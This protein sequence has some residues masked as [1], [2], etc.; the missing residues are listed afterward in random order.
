M[1]DQSVIIKWKIWFPG[2]ATSNAT[3][4]LLHYPPVTRPSTDGQLGAGAHTDCG[5][6]TLLATDAV[7]GLMV[8]DRSGRWLD[9]P[10]VPGTFICNTGDC[11]MRWS[12]HVYVST[13][14]NAV[15][16][17]PLFPGI[18]SRRPTS[19]APASISSSIEIVCRRGSLHIAGEFT[20]G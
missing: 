14:H 2:F 18:L 8:G 19:F 7:G 1:T 12:N 16:R 11:L 6:V 5:N 15:R 17:G 4:R 20:A 13:P 3:L 10:V 9:A